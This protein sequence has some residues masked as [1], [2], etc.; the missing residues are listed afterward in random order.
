MFLKYYYKVI[1]MSSWSKTIEDIYKLICTERRR[2]PSVEILLESDLAKNPKMNINRRIP[3]VEIFYE[4][5]NRPN[6]GEIIEICRSRYLNQGI[7]TRYEARTTVESFCECQTTLP[8]IVEYKWYV[9]KRIS[10]YVS[11]NPEWVSF[12]F[13]VSK[14][15]IQST[16]SIRVTSPLS[17]YLAD[18]IRETIEESEEKSPK[19]PQV[20]Y[21]IES[22][23]NNREVGN[24]AHFVQI[25]RFENP[26]Y[27][28]DKHFENLLNSLVEEGRKANPQNPPL[29]GWQW[30]T[31]QY[32]G[33]QIPLGFEIYTNGQEGRKFLERILKRRLY[34]VYVDSHRLSNLQ[35]ELDELKRRLYGFIRIIGKDP[36]EETVKVGG[37]VELENL[38]NKEKYE[39]TSISI[40]RDPK[41]SISISEFF[42]KY[43]VTLRIGEEQ[44]LMKIQEQL[45]ESHHIQ[46]P[47]EETIKSYLFGVNSK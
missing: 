39:Y 41:D 26:E 46:P 24:L 43:N 5:N 9:G 42:G 35:Q 8:N 19:E 15:E 1:N 29:L 47:S 18:F 23:I 7:S 28:G 25:I 44:G 22:T 3:V 11:R 40:Y 30:V 4:L 32:E 21:T 2:L 6:I 20:N 12:K 33:M 13:S 36:K 17:P 45:L 10:E 34:A 27:F 14:H 38:P 31:M 37:E 16:P